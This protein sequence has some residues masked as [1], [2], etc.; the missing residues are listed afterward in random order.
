MP[1]KKW[2]YKYKYLEAEMGEIL[3]KMDK[4]T[5]LFHNDF[6]T[7]NGSQP[8]Q[9][10]TSDLN[11]EDIEGDIEEISNLDSSPKKG[12]DLYKKLSKELHPDKGGNEEDFKKLNSLYQEEDILGMYVTAEKLG[13]ELEEL[14]GEEEKETFEI[15]CDALKNKIDFFQ[16]TAAWKWGNAKEEEKD[17]LSTVI[18]MQANVK[19]R[20]K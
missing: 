4:Y 18:E 6:I 16:T 13:I 19:R 9:N 1:Y 12:K 10:T 2:I 3:D 20:K 11:F 5:I 14:N 17:A 7:I 15:S 8:E